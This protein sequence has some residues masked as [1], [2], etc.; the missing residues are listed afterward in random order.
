MKEKKK[1]Y[2]VK[3]GITGLSQISKIDMSLPKLISETDELM[4]KEMTIFNYFKFIFKTVSGSGM[5]DVIK[6]KE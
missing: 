3:P 6:G 1:I 4:I 2:K 5:G